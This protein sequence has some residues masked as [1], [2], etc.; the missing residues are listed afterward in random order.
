M[1]HEKYDLENKINLI[2]DYN[3]NLNNQNCFSYDKII[4][5]K[6]GLDD[7]KISL[8][9]SDSE[10][11]EYYKSNKNDV[12]DGKFKLLNYDK[13][14]KS[15]LLKK[16]SNQFSIDVKINFYT[17]NKKIGSF[18][19]KINNNSL[20][21]YLLSQLVLSKKTNHIQL[22]IMNIDIKFNEIEHFIS[23]DLSYSDIKKEINIGNLLD[24]CCLHLREHF[25]KSVSLEEYL[26]ENICQ[27]KPLLFQIIHTLAVI[28]NEFDGFRHN[29]L[30][31]NNVFIY[32]KKKSD[33]YIE[34]DGFK[35][36]KFYVPNPGFDIKITN[37]ENAIIPK[38]YGMSNYDNP[39]IKFANQ[40][41]QYYDL[42]TFLN[43]LI[44][45][46]NKMSFY[47]Q[48]NKCD[49]ET[50]KFL[51][52]I[53]PSHI[54]G[55]NNEKMTKNIIIVRPIDLLDDKY[56]DEFRNKPSKNY[57]QETLTSH[58]YLTGKIINTF[59]DSDNYSTLGQQ[60]KIKSNHNIMTTNSRTIK[61]SNFDNIKIKRN[62]KKGGKIL[63]DI[64]DND[65]IINKRFIKEEKNLKGGNDDNIINKRFI[66][67]EHNT[68][69]I[70]RNN[71]KGGNDNAETLSY[72]AEKNNPFLSNEQKEINKKR[73]AENPIKEP[74]VLLEQKL[75]D[76]SHKPAPKSQFPPAFI[77]LYDESG[78]IANQ[79]YPYTNI[80]NQPPVQKAYT[81]NLSGP[82]ANLTAINRIYED[83]LPGDPRTYSA[84]SIFER[85]QLIDFLR[86]SIL[87]TT[88]GEEMTLSGGKNTLLSYIK[89]MDINPYSLNKN[90]YLDLARNFLLYRAAYPVRYDDKTKFIGLGKPSMG[91]NIRLYMMSLGDLRCKTINDNI[92]SDHF[93]LW[94]E[95]KYYDVIREQIIKRKVSPNF[96]APILYK[97]DSESKIDWTKLD[98]IKT[99]SYTS[100]TLKNLKIN[101]QL[102]NNSHDLNLSTSM[103]NSLIPNYFKNN[104]N[105]ISINI[106][107]KKKNNDIEILLQQQQQIQD[108]LLQ[109]QKQQIQFQQNVQQQNVPQQQIQQLQQQ[110]IKLQQQLGEIY[111]SLQKLQPSNTNKEDISI[112]SGKMLILL[113]EAPTSN[114]IQ[115]MSTIYESFGSVKK[116]MSSGY[117]TPQ[118]WKSILFQLVYSCAILQKME[119]YIEK[120]NLENNVYIKDINTDPHAVGSWIYK[121]DNVDY[122]I[123][124]YGYILMIDS[125]YVDIEINQQ[126]I[127]TQSNLKQKYKMYGKI[128]NE[129]F[130]FDMPNIQSKI[131]TQFKS[132]IDP[133]NFRH[134]LRVKGG[135]IPPDEIITLLEKMH[136][137]NLTFIKDL[138]PAY[139]SE[140]V[141]NRI[142]TLLTKTE[143]EL[144]NSLYKSKLKKG[145]I[146]AY[147][148][149]FQDYEWVIYLDKLD[150]FRSNI[151]IKSGNEYK[152]EQ[153]FNNK[154]YS[155]PDNEKI[156]FDTIKNMKYDESHIYETYNFDAI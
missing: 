156:N 153:V 115:W 84:I 91:I 12:L 111:Q 62:S 110:Q 65:D 140:F 40:S 54:R 142:G 88:D 114:I 30:K 141:H 146:L 106:S 83:V 95:I 107:S 39:S 70:I 26:K 4:M 117:H 92:N 63:D 79:I 100:D 124:N 68:E 87:D 133:D 136:K 24:T 119:I 126:F 66:K 16:Y 11:I 155:Y 36:D 3:Y 72:K 44:E 28:Q 127:K 82:T 7:I 113:T 81:I 134:N 138:I 85:K 19:D 77:P 45:G 59:M 67:E 137:Y 105:D 22:P 135:S 149:R 32:L 6:I 31:L 103:F 41:N 109:I 120:F 55:L 51:N 49:E 151:L 74:P 21:S 29:N 46:T 9:N 97:I 94:R 52:I 139:F 150:N 14:S 90:P 5:G 37:F 80:R 86:N 15:F 148:K 48:N 89:L 99:N 123:P 69:K 96:I 61:N 121:V 43:D 116:M 147:L 57:V 122:Y 143:V 38:F 53:F 18:D 93:D 13:E 154:L 64:D 129:N 25:F 60:D 71:L 20:F 35:K 10:S 145:L 34:Y 2:Y 128:Y 131:L 102:I 118:I 33:S 132:I 75:Y 152:I 104:T 101:Q 98:I 56:F 58:Q 8:P 78:N 144:T 50:K 76:T 112:N 17:D 47:Q 23:N 1:E 125:K 27:Y 42:F 108:Q 130:D 73:T